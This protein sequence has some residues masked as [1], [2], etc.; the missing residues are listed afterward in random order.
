MSSNPKSSLFKANE[1][2]ISWFWMSLKMSGIHL[3][4]AFLGHL[5]VAGL[6]ITWNVD[7]SRFSHISDFLTAEYKAAL[8]PKARMTVDFGQGPDEFEAAR[9]SEIIWNHW[10]PGFDQSWGYFRN[11]AWVYFIFIPLSIVALKRLSIRLNEP[12]HDRGGRL[13]TG[14]E[15]LRELKKEK[16]RLDLPLGHRI[17][18]PWEAEVQNIMM[19]G[20]IGSG[21]STALCQIVHRLKQRG[22]R[23]LIVD[24]KGE[25]LAKFYDR[26]QDVILNPEDSRSVGWSFPNE[27]ETL[28]DVDIFCDS[29]VP[30][31]KDEVANFFNKITRNFLKALAVT[32]YI[33]GD[34]KLRTNREFYRILSL[35]APDLQEVLKKTDLGIS[36]LPYI[37]D[38]SSKQTQGV[39]STLSAYT[40]I[41]FYLSR[42][43]GP[44]SFTQW[45]N[46]G[47][48][49]IFLTCRPET[50]DTFKPLLSLIV[51][52][53]SKK[54]Q[55]LRDSLQRRIFFCID[56]LGNLHRLS[57]PETLGV[58]RSK[59]ASFLLASQNYSRISK[60]YG[61]H[62]SNTI[63]DNCSS[64]LFFRVQAPD[65][66]EWL[67][68]SFSEREVSET[69][70][71]H[72]MGPQSLR[73]GLTL[74]RKK[75]M[76]KIILASEFYALPNL[77]CYLRIQH[78]NPALTQIP[79]VFFPEINEPFMMAPWLHLDNLYPK[80]N[81]PPP[82]KKDTPDPKGSEDPLAF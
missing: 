29:L 12:K 13:I 7:R 19:I 76:K 65:T 1:I 57:L 81:E 67:E 69:E 66:A 3:L 44:F 71:S 50:R 48:G 75:K 32:T 35:P 62:D 41:F 45:I 52:L 59:G 56:E 68:R 24:F 18:L 55:G 34:H 42:L 78:R 4:I 37:S 72:S 54:L 5:M 10:K 46:E 8:I 60:I 21:K 64:R 17:R 20:T 26:K 49:M 38:P 25:F 31:A 15:L 43:D 70:E 23:A 28:G 33:S 36:C 30:E 9:V 61:D 27:F 6:L 58:A 2:L 74:G 82:K 16:I 40:Q 79:P 53:V 39:L 22:E 80:T 51:D 11:T 63:L 73:D 47:K 77:S 14:K